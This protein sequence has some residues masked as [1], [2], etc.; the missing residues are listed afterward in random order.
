MVQ[1]KE[2]KFQL[3][4]RQLK[5]MYR[6]LYRNGK[7]DFHFSYNDFILALVLSNNNPRLKT[8]KKAYILDYTEAFYAAINNLDDKKAYLKRN[9]QLD[10]LAYNLQNTQKELSEQEIKISNPLMAAQTATYLALA[11][12]N[13]NKN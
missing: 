8:D 3:N 5:D 7:V 12:V 2:W 11:V 6:W 1:R 10:R 4:D 9:E 13:I